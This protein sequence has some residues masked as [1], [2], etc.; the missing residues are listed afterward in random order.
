MHAIEQNTYFHAALLGYVKESLAESSTS[1]NFRQ[2]KMTLK[3]SY[4]IIAPETT[5]LAT[6]AYQ[7]YA[8]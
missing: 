8:K 7:W 6:Q 2:K 4:H 1:S 5:A 3:Y